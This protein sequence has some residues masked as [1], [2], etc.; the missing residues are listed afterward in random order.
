[1]WGGGGAGGRHDRGGGGGGDRDG[2]GGAAE[3]PPQPVHVEADQVA[4]P[5]RRAVAPELIDELAHG[6][7]PAGAEQQGGQQR[8][9]FGRAD[10]GPLLPVPDF[11]RAEDPEQPPAGRLNHVSI[12]TQYRVIRNSVSGCHAHFATANEVTSWRGAGSRRPPNRG[13]VGGDAGQCR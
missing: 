12:V 10:L 1:G 6:D 8:P 13:V 2:A 9:P 7:R 4:G 3:G 5:R 11:E